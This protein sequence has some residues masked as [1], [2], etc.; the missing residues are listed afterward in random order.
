METYYRKVI[1]IKAEDSP[2]VR[3]ALYEISQGL[4]V[5]HREMI[6]GVLSYREYL[7]RR[8]TWD[9]IRQCIGLDAEFYE[10]ASVLMFPPHWLN[11]CEAF[12][13]SISK[14]ERRAKAIGIDPGEGDA[15]TT[16]SA[17]DE[18]GLIEQ[19][20]K[21]T[22]DTSVITGDAI[23]FMRKHGVSPDKVMFDR[24]GGGKE[25]A[26]RLRRHGYNVRTVAFGESLL[27]DLKR[28]G[29]LR[30][31]DEKFANIEDRYTYKNRRAE[32]FG[33]LR[34]LIDPK[35]TNVERYGGFAIPAEYT[36]LRRQLSLIPLTFDSEGRLELLPKNRRGVT[37]GTNVDSRV[38][39]L[40]EL[41][42]KSPD[43][44]DSLVLA[45]FG[46]VHK[47]YRPMAGAV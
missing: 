16:M 1:R 44:A 46:M 40:V 38:K 42:G 28:T 45:C 26:D 4:P 22:P 24:G 36:E 12:A 19:V 18:L 9:P 8:E 33:I 34:L 7:K 31:Y 2:N 20:S 43:E 47:D 37:L 15:N 5:S 32:M 29:V 11:E 35:G 39:T 27:P 17:V 6:P 30:L 23:A 21:R 25:H 3:A 13:A 10:D 14:R 41:I